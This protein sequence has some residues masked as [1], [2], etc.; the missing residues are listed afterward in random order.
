[1]VQYGRAMT[2]GLCTGPCVHA[3]KEFGGREDLLEDLRQERVVAGCY[4]LRPAI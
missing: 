2:D 3:H 1:V 4:S